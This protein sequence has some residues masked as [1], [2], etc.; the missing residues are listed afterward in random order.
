MNDR[1]KQVLN[2]LEQEPNDPFLIYAA[3]IEYRNFDTKKAIAYFE[4]LL[5]E[6]PQYLPTYYHAASL[7]A[8]LEQIEQAKETYEK[9]VELAEATDEKMALR[10]LRNAYA[11]FLFE[12]DED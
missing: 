3:A 4:I 9:G 10:E 2:L 12:W 1:L 11:N 7:Y 8:D 5:K 6:H